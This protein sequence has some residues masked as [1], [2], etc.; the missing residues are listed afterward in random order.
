MSKVLEALKYVKENK[1]ALAL[2][3]FFGM[4]MM[5]LTI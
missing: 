4:F 1:K 2:G 5:M 3:F